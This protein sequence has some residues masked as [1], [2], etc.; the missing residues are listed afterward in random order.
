MAEY[1]LKASALITDALFELLKKNSFEKISITELT[2]KAGVARLS[3]YRNF[4]SKE[5]IVEKFFDHEF[6]N[7]MA[8]LAKQDQSQVSL[9]SIMILSFSYWQKK[10]QQIRMLVRDGQIDLIYLSFQ[11]NMQ[12]ILQRYQEQFSLTQRQAEFVEGGIMIVLLEWIQDG[13]QETPEEIAADV[14]RR[15]LFNI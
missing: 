11:K 4:K 10:H 3:Y 15:F 6:K 8:E 7:F 13:C 14:G 12:L 1:S 2:Q 9:Q 5:D